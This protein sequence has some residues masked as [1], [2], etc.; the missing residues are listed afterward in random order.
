MMLRNVPGGI[1]HSGL[2]HQATIAEKVGYCL[3]AGFGRQRGKLTNL[4]VSE[5]DPNGLRN[6][7][8]RLC[9]GSPIHRCVDVRAK[10]RIA[11][12]AIEV[13]FVAAGHHDFVNPAGFISGRSLAGVM[14]CRHGSPRTGFMGIIHCI[15]CS[16][17]E[18][19]RQGNRRSDSDWSPASM[20][21]AI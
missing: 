4:T 18:V 1:S 2:F 8:N 11:P 7:V 13:R 20:G 9:G 10:S 19:I 5:F 14:S 15:L 3:G 21:S 16:I 12:I 17:R 6:P